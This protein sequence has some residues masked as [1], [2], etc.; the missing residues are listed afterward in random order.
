MARRSHLSRLCLPGLLACAAGACGGAERR[1]DVP[2]S[3]VVEDLRRS[4]GSIVQDCG[5]ASE[6]RD[7]DSC[8]VQP[9]GEC[10]EAALG[11][12]R[13]AHGVR[14]YFTSEGD[15]VRVDFIVLDDR[16][17]GCDLIQ[18][19][20]FSSDPLAKVKTIVER[21]RR[22][23]WKPHPEIDRCLLLVPEDCKAASAAK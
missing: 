4:A 8:T 21:C 14:S 19:Q 18:V 7:E 23:T 22:A 12:C 6:L 3:T 10:L 2:P 5:G 13:P 9:V 17:G 1:P 15:P 16:R 11:Q 20:D